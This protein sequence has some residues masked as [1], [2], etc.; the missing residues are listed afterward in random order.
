MN[1]SSG[2]QPEE[3]EAAAGNVEIRGIDDPAGKR[4]HLPVRLPAEV[5]SGSKLLRGKGTASDHR[6]AAPV[7]WNDGARDVACL[8]GGKEESNSGDFLGASDTTQRHTLF[9]AL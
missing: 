9:V 6:H 7:H 4:S 5:L 1:V 8:I 2:K 3:P